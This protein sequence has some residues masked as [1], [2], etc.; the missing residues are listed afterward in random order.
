MQTRHAAEIERVGREKEDT[1]GM[2]ESQV[3]K[4]LGN[5]D[6]VIAGLRRRVEE[7]GVLN[8]HYEE[9]IEGQRSEIVSLVK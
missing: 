1:L 6:E 3:K 9:M 4:T 2:V 8:C 5:K 7:L